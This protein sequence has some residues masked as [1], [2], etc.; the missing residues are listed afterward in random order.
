MKKNIYV[1]F[2]LILCITFSHPLG[3]S[4]QTGG[5]ETIEE[6]CDEGIPSSSKRHFMRS[7]TDFLSI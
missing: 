6:V 7:I 2:L 5:E 3:I 4:A 1:A